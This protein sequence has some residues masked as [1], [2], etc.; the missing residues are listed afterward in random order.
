MTNLLNDSGINN[1]ND[2]QKMQDDLEN[3]LGN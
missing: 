3:T 1:L 2:V